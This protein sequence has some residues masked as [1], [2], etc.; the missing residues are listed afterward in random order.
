[1]QIR[2]LF[3]IAFSLYLGLSPIYWFPYVPPITFGLIKFLLFGFICTYALI[4]NFQVGSKSK[5]NIPGGNI[6]LF[7]ILGML[8]IVFLTFVL[9]DNQSNLNTVINFFQILLFVLA[10]GTIISFNQV[11][12][13]IRLSLNILS[14]F[15]VLSVIFMFVIPFTINP[16]N[17]ELFLIDTGFGGLRTGW[18]PAIGLFVPFIF[19][20]YGSIIILSIYLLSQI[21]TG[22]RA[23]FYLSVISLLPL[24]YTQRSWRFKARFIGILFFSIFG[25]L[26]YNPSLLKGLRVFD[27]L[28]ESSD[29][30]SLST[31]RVNL[32]MDAWQSILN[33]PISGN[34]VSSTFLGE[35][36]HNVFVRGW[37]YYGVFYFIFSILLVV[38]TLLLCFY[39]I[40]YSKS[41][42]N[43]RFFIAATLVIFYG[44]LVGMVEPQIIF[45]N[46]TNFSI[47]WFVFALIAS[48]KF[49]S[50]NSDSK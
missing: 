28:S 38:Y 25:V 42:N 15:V 4:F 21:L 24:L 30:D 35:E 2:R 22:G 19:Y 33:N 46:F 29:L 23:G 13:V 27:S 39:K 32:M 3:V 12:N 18:S 36:V 31:G 1:M 41:K 26:V 9:G 34:A 8:A 40:K 47:W 50:I 45:G 5:L 48:K 10:T 11:L 37:V 17:S 16:I 20:V 14:F 44:V 6:F 7:L 49:K 43:R